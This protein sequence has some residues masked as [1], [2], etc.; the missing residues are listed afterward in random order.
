M[1]EI[2]EKI[3]EKIPKDLRRWLKD[4]GHFTEFIRLVRLCEYSVSDLT[5]TFINSQGQIEYGIK[6]WLES[7]IE[8]RWVNYK[9]KSARYAD[10]LN[11]FSLNWN[12]K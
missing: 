4:N 1:G 11:I 12:Q 5:H 6:R 3:E 7:P 8:S 2:E 9:H 10:F